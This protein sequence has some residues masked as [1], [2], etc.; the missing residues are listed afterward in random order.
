MF[1]SLR[2][3]IS[4]E[5]KRVIENLHP[6][7]DKVVCI[8][9]KADDE[10][11]DTE[12]LIKVYGSLL[13]SLARVFKKPEVHYVHIC[14]F[15]EAADADLTRTDHKELIDKDSGAI[16]KRLDLLPRDCAGRKL[17]D[18]L[19]RITTLRA[20]ISIIY[21]L[22]SMMPW[23]WGHENRQKYLIENLEEAYLKAQARNSSIAAGDYPPVEEMK[24]K[25]RESNLDF[26]TAFNFSRRDYEK[27]QATLSHILDNESGRIATYI[28]RVFASRDEAL[29]YDNG[30]NG[31]ESNTKGI[32][33]RLIKDAWYEDEQ[34]EINAVTDS[35][36]PKKQ[37]ASSFRTKTLLCCILALFYGV[38]LASKEDKHEAVIAF[39]TYIF[40]LLNRS[41]KSS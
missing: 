29:Q 36:R 13:W 12:S 37:N 20:T 38:Y 2:T 7:E 32:V 8:L 6:Y 39:R 5:F 16:R 15:K 18:L 10:R 3:D 31:R 40:A 21:Q 27:A 28:E 22:K 23:I 11:M 33:A 30:R 17:N 35:G 14:S 41:S 1:D 9:N 25:L 34:E 4:D 24:R 26:K 19:K